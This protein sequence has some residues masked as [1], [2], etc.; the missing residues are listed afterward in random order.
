MSNDRSSLRKVV[1]TLAVLLLA[2]AASGTVHLTVN[3]FDVSS[4]EMAPG[5]TCTFEI[6]CT[7]AAE[8]Y[9]V[10]IG[11]EFDLVGGFIHDLTD[12]SAGFL[13]YVQPGSNPP[14]YVGYYVGGGGYPFGA[15]E[16]LHFGFFFQPYE[17]FYQPLILMDSLTYEILDTVDIFVGGGPVDDFDPPSPDPMQWLSAPAAVDASSITMTAVTASDES[18]VEYYF[19]CT[20]PGGHDGQWDTSST[21]TD[22]G[23]ASG[24]TYTYKVIARDM[25]PYQNPT[26]ASL[27]AS[28]TTDLAVSSGILNPGY[29]VPYDTATGVGVL[30]NNGVTAVS[31]T[32]SDSGGINNLD[33]LTIDLDTPGAVILQSTD[34]LKGTGGT[35]ITDSAV[36]SLDLQTGHNLEYTGFL[37][38]GG[39]AHLQGS[40]PGSM[41]PFPASGGN[42]IGSITVDEVGSSIS[43]LL[44]GDASIASLWSLVTANSIGSIY[45]NSDLAVAVTTTVGNIGTISVGNNIDGAISSA[46]T[47]ANIYAYDINA[48]ITAASGIIG[49]INCNRIN[50]AITAATGD[51]GSDPFPPRHINVN[52]IT[53]LGSLNAPF[54]DVTR[55]I[56]AGPV[57]GPIVA[58]NVV[59]VIIVLTGDLSA[60]ITAG[61]D[62]QAIAVANGDITGTI[63]SY[64]TIGAITVTGDLTSQIVTTTGFS[65]AIS[66]LGDITPTGS[67]T[68]TSGDFSGAIYCDSIRGVINAMSGNIGNIDAF[69]IPGTI[70]ADMVI[71]DITAFDSISGDITAGN[72]IGDI[73]VYDFG[74]VSGD[75]LA[76]GNIGDIFINNGSINSP[77]SITTTT[78]SIGNITVMSGN[79]AGSIVAGVNIGTISV[80][81]GSITGSITATAGLTGDITADG[82]ISGPITAGGTIDLIESY[83]GNI[84]SVINIDGSLWMIYAD[85]DQSNNQGD[86]AAQMNILG[87]L[88]YVMSG[89][90]IGGTIETGPLFVQIDALKDVTADI[91]SSGEIRFINIG[92]N[93]QSQIHAD[94]GFSYGINI[95][96]GITAAGGLISSSGGFS[97]FANVTVATGDIAGVIRAQGNISVD[98][99][100]TTGAITGTIESTSGDLTGNIIAG[101]GDISSI[102]IGGDIDGS[103]IQAEDDILSIIAGG[104]LA[105]DIRASGGDISLIDIGGDINGGTIHA[106]DDIVS[107]IVAGDIENIGEQT[108]EIIA[109]TDLNGTGD[110]Q[111]IVAGGS[112]DAEVT[113]KNIDLVRSG[114]SPGDN[115]SGIYTAAS[116]VT[117]VDAGAARVTGLIQSGAAVT[118]S[119]LLKIIDSGIKYTIVSNAGPSKAVFDISYYGNNRSA[120]VDVE[121]KSGWGY[122]IELRTVNAGD[123]SV[124][125]AVFDLANLTIHDNSINRFLGVVTVEGSTLGV[126][127]LGNS[128]WLTGLIV[129]ENIADQITVS[130]IDLLAASTIGGLPSTAGLAESITQMGIGGGD[131]MAYPADGTFRVPLSSINTTN[132]FGAD[133]DATTFNSSD[134]VTVDYSPAVDSE[135]YITFEDGVWSGSIFPPDLEHLV[136]SEFGT[137][138][139]AI[140]FAFDGDTVIVANGTYTGPGNRDL[141]F[142]GKA[143]TVRSENGPELCIIDCEGSV[144]DPHRGFIFQNA[145]STSSV[146]EGFTIINGNVASSGAGILVLTSSPTVRNCIFNN[147]SAYCPAGMDIRSSNLILDNVT[148]ANSTPLGDSDSGFTESVVEILGTFSIQNENVDVFGGRFNGTGTI[149]LDANSTLTIKRIPICDT[150]AITGITGA[151][152]DFTA[153]IFSGTDWVIPGVPLNGPIVSGFDIS[154]AISPDTAPD[155]A[156]LWWTGSEIQQDLSSGGTAEATFY[157]G[158]KIDIF[159]ELYDIKPGSLTEGQMLYDG[160]LL[161]ADVGE[162]RVKEFPD[163][164]LNF[165]D[166]QGQETELVFTPAAGFLSGSEF[167][168]FNTVLKGDQLMSMRFGEAQQ[169]GG[170]VTDFANN[171]TL[172]GT[173]TEFDITPASV[174]VGIT[175]ISSNIFGPGNIEIE[176]GAQLIITDWAVVD[177]GGSVECH[178]DPNTGGH[179]VVFGSLVVEGNAT[180]ENTNVDVMLLNVEGDIQNNNIILRDVI[181]NDGTSTGY[182]GEFFV[183]GNATI[184]CNNIIS[185][186]DRYLDMDPDPE[187]FPRPNISNNFITVIINEG[188]LGAHG[189]LLELR[190]ADYDCYDT[191]NPDCFSGA[192]QVSSSSSGFN[193]TENWVL[194]QLI[195]NDNAKLNLTNRPG[196]EF[197][198][199]GDPGIDPNIAS[200]I[201]TVYVKELI[202]YPDAVLNTALQTL[203]YQDLI[204]V[205]ID[206]TEI[207]RNPS[208]LFLPFDNGSR[209]EDIPLLGFSLAVISMDDTT[210]SPHNEFDIRVRQRLRDTDDIQ[211]IPPSLPKEGSIKRIEGDSAIPAGA[212]G[213]MEMRTEALGLQ[214]ASSVAAKGA[215]ARAGDEDITIEFE[216]LF[217]DDP[218]GEAEIIVY[219]SDKPDVGDNLV[220]VARISPPLSFLPGAIGS[221]RFATFKDVVPKGSLNFTRGTYIELE[222]RGT[223]ARC[224]IDEWDPAVH[225]SGHCKDV[226]GNTGWVD[227]LDFLTVI[228][229]YGESSEITPSSVCLEGV[230]SADGYLDMSDVASWDWLMDKGTYFASDL[231]IQSVPLY[232]GGSTSGDARPSALGD[233][234]GDIALLSG[235]ENLLIS[236]KRRV[237]TGS[238]LIDK[239]YGFDDNYL[240]LNSADIT[241]NKANVRLVTDSNDEVYMIHMEDGLVRLSDSLPVI[242]PSTGTISYANDPRYGVNANVQIGL[243]KSGSGYNEYWGRPIMDAAFDVDY[244]T[245][246]FVYIVPVVV[247]P[248]ISDPND[249]KPS[250]TA[251]A[252]IQV[253]NPAEPDGSYLIVKIYS[254]TQAGLAGDNRNLNHLREIEVDLSV[255]PNLYVTNAN[256]INESDTL[257][258]YNSN[259]GDVENNLRLTDPGNSPLIPGPVGLYY[260]DNDNRIYMA[261]SQGPQ[262]ATEV[263]VYGFNANTLELERT[264]D[265]QQMQH[266]TG[267]TEDPL[268]NTLWIAGFSMHDIPIGTPDATA[269]PFYHPYLVDV[270]TG[271]DS[272]TAMEV[273]VNNDPNVCDLALPTSIVWIESPPACAQANIAGGDGVNIVDFAELNDSWLD[274]TCSVPESCT[275]DI[276]KLGYVDLDDLLIMARFWLYAG[277]F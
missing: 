269:Y 239:L 95:N 257:W 34:D 223:S 220:E 165:V 140:N 11:F 114:R 24:S 39:T 30:Y 100:A 64:T 31:V 25:S 134:I 55:I 60:D 267:I 179:I 35:L 254:D 139:E 92:G 174:P 200:Y 105:G 149:D 113:A 73:A 122:D 118:A 121:I 170:S 79:L 109:D 4:Y 63:T 193:P 181:R 123:G 102:I 166:S 241:P 178:P 20:T 42:S 209:F 218:H 62:I 191:A 45:V 94:T 236:G 173:P 29:Y 126:I 50:A 58:G 196:F 47:V 69:T 133:D 71:G 211:P 168:T 72:D 130:S 57:S 137:I 12:P 32:F 244:D 275:A 237:S 132:V 272:V 120:N 230:F 96:N 36:V 259:T 205:D 138:Q 68:A 207:Q 250:Y 208:D 197:Y 258:V 124:N 151:E 1:L 65:G 48:A 214:S 228:G 10:W 176:A 93:L 2:S 192:F 107:I 154:W 80:P 222:L 251:A 268:T 202:L 143:I 135:I 159:G 136:P 5:D 198:D 108:F 182:G 169:L 261:S 163:N 141:D 106:K 231:C 145:E 27:P 86:I 204:I 22:T 37:W 271:D 217:M 53:S 264:I 177:L 255:P 128:S 40:D 210:L 43:Q 117:L 44:I 256:S 104:S 125:D 38:G 90:N 67:M 70:S 212:R 82:D 190:A 195:I 17:P 85:T 175:Y 150:E 52:Q 229:E 188:Q 164:I 216:Y 235:T 61:G 194:Q 253:T 224:F 158:G 252:K 131:S 161:S 260:S 14:F 127:D 153:A 110:V 81:A 245:N 199:F 240:C 189:T 56:S 119:P 21:Y 221:D 172:V 7:D 6:V 75:I 263:L 232:A 99:A 26:A 201:E 13:A 160:L 274:P 89:G 155:S 247:N 49:E 84:T 206:G 180:L 142:M 66:I 41:I 184:S 242:G 16:G 152:L 103:L 111:S 144:G 101:S 147:N 115:I 219:L 227:D 33:T 8:L 187:A 249:D 23:L 265:I 233:P 148:L 19:D 87:S 225:C 157:A 146:L 78:G 248:V 266:V 167:N 83:N 273:F 129:Q 243:G 46:G 203:Y 88:G 186:G 91:H 238:R 112:I 59:G 76:G 171:I 183:E 3:N 213:V 51:I 74:G 116:K 54:G 234:L 246:G 276:D 262:Y 185:Y 98:I 97:N 270:P 226:T 15:D 77:A 28:A 215:F 18:G 162:F 156:V 9:E 277:C